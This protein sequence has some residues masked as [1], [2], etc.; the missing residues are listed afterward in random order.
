MRHRIVSNL[1]RI[2]HYKY[3]KGGIFKPKL[4]GSLPQITPTLREIQQ[5][6]PELV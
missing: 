1:S 2:S 5:Y 3:P 6:G 4:A